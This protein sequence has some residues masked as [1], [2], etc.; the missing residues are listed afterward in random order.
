MVRRGVCLEVWRGC[1][2]RCGLTLEY[3]PELTQ[4]VASRSIS[5]VYDLS[6]ELE[7]Q[8]LLKTLFD[9]LINGK[10]YV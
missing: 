4:E 6:G 5:M 3:T 10:R 1:V 9:T 2:L 7:K 8:D